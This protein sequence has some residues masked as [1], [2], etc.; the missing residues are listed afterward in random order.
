GSKM[1]NGIISGLGRVGHSL[2]SGTEVIPSGITGGSTIRYRTPSIGGLILAASYTP[3][4]DV[5]P[6]GDEIDGNG[7]GKSVAE[8]V[9]S[10]AARYTSTYGAYTTTV[11][12]GYEQGNRTLKEETGLHDGHH[13][14]IFYS[15]GARVST[16]SADF[17]AGY[18]ERRADT[19]FAGGLPDDDYRWFDVAAAY[20]FGPWAVSGGV[21]YLVRD[22]EDF[23]G[24]PNVDQKMFAASL[25][26]QLRLAPGL[27]IKTGITVW[28]I[29][30]ADSD[31]KNVDNDATTFTLTT[32]MSF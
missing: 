4:T 28:E 15:V 31:G 32:E 24:D 21:G 14:S 6:I 7:D 18:G 2:K 17:A 11:Y 26:A 20:T 19:N 13:N 10:L 29:E 25:S 27:S 1:V 12:V 9:W 5:D 23:I 22:D 3:E 8:D 30:N 16:E